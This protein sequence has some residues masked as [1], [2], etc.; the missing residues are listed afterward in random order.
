MAWVFRHS[1]CEGIHSL[2]VMATKKS[3]TVY[4]LMHCSSVPFRFFVPADASHFLKAGGSFL[5]LY[6]EA[7]F[8][9]ALE[10]A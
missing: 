6:P 8:F 3:W 10:Y 1:S 2:R 5:I 9:I 7:C 4:V